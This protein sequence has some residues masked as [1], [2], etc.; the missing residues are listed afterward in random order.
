MREVLLL[1]ARPRRA[2]GTLFDQLK[3]A[4]RVLVRQVLQRRDTVEHNLPV[5]SPRDEPDQERDAAV[6]EYL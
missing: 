6:P 4:V 5:L 3:A 1:H 2:G